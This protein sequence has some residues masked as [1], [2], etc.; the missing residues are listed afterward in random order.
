MRPAFISGALAAAG[1]LKAQIFATLAVLKPRLHVKVIFLST[2][3]SRHTEKRFVSYKMGFGV[4]AVRK[5]A[6]DE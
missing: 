3:K 1:C 5:N 4:Q 2:L 6:A